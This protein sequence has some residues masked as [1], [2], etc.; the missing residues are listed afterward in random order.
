MFKR[1]NP[2]SPHKR[3]MAW[4]LPAGGYRRA[5]RYLAH[6]VG[7]LPGTPYRIAAGLASGAAVSM[8]PFIGFHF[9]LAMLLSLAVRGNL[10]ASAVGTVVGNPWTFPLIW[11]WTY[12]L[13]H[14]LLGA[15]GFEL[16]IVGFTISGIFD[17]LETVFWPMLLGSLPSALAT[18]LMVFF[19]L[20]SAVAQ[21]QRARRRRLRRRARR[22]RIV[23]RPRERE[24]S[25]TPS[26]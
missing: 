12:A 1:K 8:T 11:A 10:I 7:R 13:G 24:L 2:L 19:P 16:P 15:R 14:W 23:R 6:R 9:V 4:I 22:L 18:W 25:A 5:A 3:V 17:S 21:Y 20:R 26:E